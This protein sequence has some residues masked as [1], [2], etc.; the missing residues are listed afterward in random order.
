MRAGLKLAPVPRDD[1]VRVNTHVA[2]I[3]DSASVEADVRAVSAAE[4]TIWLDADEIF[5]AGKA[6]G[7]V[8]AHLAKIR[9]AVLR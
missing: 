6:R 7:A 1:V 3:A 8:A 5:P 4:G 2:S 9:V